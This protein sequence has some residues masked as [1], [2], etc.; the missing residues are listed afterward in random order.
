MKLVGAERHPLGRQ[1]PT[2][3]PWSAL[4]EYSA[5]FGAA[6]NSGST[7]CGMGMAGSPATTGQ[8]VDEK[9]AD[10]LRGRE[11]QGPTAGKRAVR[12]FSRDPN[13]LFNKA[14]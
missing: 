7:A 10:E 6:Q 11:R 8:H 4:D 5:R 13:P 12:E 3:L 14:R 9:A 2:A 1:S